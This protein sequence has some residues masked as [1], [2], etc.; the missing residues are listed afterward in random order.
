MTNASATLEP[1]RQP[2]RLAAASFA[3][4]ALIGA[5]LPAGTA[6]GDSL[7]YLA[8]NGVTVLC[9]DAPV[10]VSATIN[11]VTYT[12]RVRAEITLE[13]A[14]TSCTS[15][16]TD[17]SGMFVTASTF[18]G[19]IRHWD[20]SNVTDMNSMFLSAAAFNRDISHWDTSRVTDMSFMFASARAFNQ[21]IGAWDTSNVTDMRLMFGI[22]TAFN[23]DI[24]G[25]DTSNVTTMQSMFFQARAFDQD[26]GGWDTSGATNMRGMFEQA[27]SF[28]KDLSG[29]CVSGIPV[30]PLEFDE[31]AVAWTLPDSRPLW[32]TCPV[33][34]SPPPDP[35]PVP[36]PDPVDPIEPSDPSPPPDPDPAP[37]ADPVDPI[38]PSDPIEPGD[39]IEPSEPEAPEEPET[40]DEP[41]ELDEPTIL[42]TDVPA[43]SVHARNINRLVAAGITLGCGP[44]AFCPAEPVSRQQMASFL[45]RALTLDHPEVVFDFT[46]V[47][48]QSTHYDAI[49][50]LATSG[51]TLGCGPG[52]F[53]PT[54]PVTREQM[55][56]FLSRG[57]DLDLPALRFDFTDVAAGSVHADAIQA[58]AA[59][60]ITLGCGPGVFC[61]SSPVRRDQ[62]ASFLVRALDL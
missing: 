12:K 52:V 56:S 61:P 3:L 32:G 58:L 1:R 51:I 42:F 34:P 49:Q 16:V 36:P 44:G 7:I 43:D 15:A 24:G 23:R 29:W 8:P 62:M 22:A 57:L 2:G 60:E 41:A 26:I 5:L 27:E 21:G 59:A 47:T 9:P 50:A 55:A 48:V 11:G 37:P 45:T 39:P 10:G 38:E 46:D 35:D 40:P 53:C 13:N 30:R 31:G 17:M 18:N 54:A 25:W 14:A 19:D 20:T 6:A 28:N 4:V 33:D